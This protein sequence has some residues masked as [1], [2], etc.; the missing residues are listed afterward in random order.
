MQS[1]NLFTADITTAFLQGKEFPDG[2]DRVIWIKLPRD[3]E[4]LLGLEGEH[5]QLM[6]LTKPMYGLCDA[7]RAWF[8]EATERILQVGDGRIVQHPLDACLWPMT[9]SPRMHAHHRNYLECLAYTWMICL[10]ASI[11]LTPCPR[12]FKTRSI[13]P[14]PS[15]SGSWKISWSIAEAR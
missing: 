7:P 1:F 6:K 15:E 11:L 2:S 12:R 3:G 5:G 9:R 4:R 13:N 14:S 8:E 10:A